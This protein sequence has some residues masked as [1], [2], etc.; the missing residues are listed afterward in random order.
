MGGGGARRA[1]GV[2]RAVPGHVDVGDDGEHDAGRLPAQPLQ[3]GGEP[4]RELLLA[5]LLQLLLGAGS[6]LPG[7]R[8]QGGDRPVSE[9]VHVDAAG[10]PSGVGDRP[11]GRA[12]G[13]RRAAVLRRGGADPELA[14]S[15][16]YGLTQQ[17]RPQTLE[18]DRTQLASF[19]VENK[20]LYEL[21]IQVPSSKYTTDEGQLQEILDSFELFTM[22]PGKTMI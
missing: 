11:R 10:D 22:E 1:R 16:Q 14:A 18:W 4:L 8:S 7:G 20:R 3:R 5:L 2:L 21:R 6:G 13:E 17:E 19:G 9:R 12:G 15:N